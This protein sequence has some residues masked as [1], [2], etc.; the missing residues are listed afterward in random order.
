MDARSS[1]LSPSYNFIG[2]MSASPAT[3]SVAGDQSNTVCSLDL[4]INHINTPQ[5]R[6]CTKQT[7][8]MQAAAT[9]R[10]FMSIQ[11]N[12]LWSGAMNENSPRNSQRLK[13]FSTSELLLLSWLHWLDASLSLKNILGNNNKAK[14]DK[15]PAVLF[16]LKNIWFK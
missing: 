6:W 4:I 3:V 12:L 8:L 5:K 10:S 11:K 14:C 2:I 15:L 1:K 9:L 7:D 16:K 13:R